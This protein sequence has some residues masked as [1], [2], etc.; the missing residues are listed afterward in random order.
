MFFLKFCNS[1][2]EQTKHNT[3]Y[4][5]VLVDLEKWWL[6]ADLLKLCRHHSELL[7]QDYETRDV[8]TVRLT[9]KQ[10]GESIPDKL[11]IGDGVT[12]M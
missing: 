8:I 10:P 9:A 7:H 4:E 12:W 1:H 11:L 6:H 2:I 5:W 3:L